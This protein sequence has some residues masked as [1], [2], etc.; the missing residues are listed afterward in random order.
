[1]RPLL[2]LLIACTT[3]AQDRPRARELGL[4]PGILP[5]GPLNAITDVAGVRVGQVTIIEGDNVRTGVT[6]IVP[7]SGNLFQQKVPAAV[8]VG[9][10]FGKLAG[11]TQVEELGA[12]ETPI[13]LTN[14]LSV[15]RAAEAVVEYTLEQPGNEEVRSVNPV[16]GE[17]NDA[18]LNDVRGLHV[19]KQHVRRA[20]ESAR[21]GPVEE[22]AVGAGTG[23]S[24]FGWKGGI[25]TSSRLLEAGGA[26]YTVGAL[27]QSNYGGTLDMDGVPVGKEMRRQAGGAGGGDGSIMMI[28]ATDAP[29]DARQL[30]R[31]AR[32]AMLAIGRTGSPSTHGSG[33]FVLSFT[34]AE[35]LRLGFGERTV[36]QVPRFPE[37]A[38]TPLF[39]AA[40]EST[41]EAIYNSMLKAKTMTGYRG[42]R[43][44]AI[45]LDRLREILS[46]YGR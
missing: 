14:T 42:R 30:T 37:D 19:T 4:A 22:G 5:P 43:V 24:A 29:L 8:H 34:T 45:P 38:I 41:E 23:T 28:V 35:A 7:H 11:S 40:M 12:L 6:A 32:R 46:R 44:E 31:L 13:V 27:V 33:D 2:I 9:N 20:I 39:Q 10:A 16:V 1:M 36:W 17:T 26:R 25:G 21:G 15:W 18:G 3:F